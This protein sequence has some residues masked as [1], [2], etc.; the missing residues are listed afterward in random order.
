MEMGNQLS[1]SWDARCSFNW[2]RQQ[3]NNQYIQK[4]KFHKKY[5]KTDCKSPQNHKLLIDQIMTV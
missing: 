4:S 3:I 1:T 5:Y 2:W